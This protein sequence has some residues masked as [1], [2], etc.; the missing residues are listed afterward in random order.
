M[1]WKSEIEKKISEFVGTKITTKRFLSISGGSI[2]ESYKVSTNKGDFFVKKNSATQ[3][4]LMFNKETRGLELLCKT[5][6]IDTPEILGVVEIENDS[7]LILKYIKSGK[8]C[9]TFWDDFG[10]KIA[11]LHK[12]SNSYFGL[13]HD[14]YIGSLKQNNSE[15]DSWLDF[16]REERLERQVEL[17]RNNNAIDRETV[18]AFQR[19]YTKLE[20]IFPKESPALLHGDLWSGNFMV[21]ENGNP[22][23]IDPAAYYGHREMDLGM[24]KLFGGFDNEFYNS[25][26]NQYQLENGWEERLNYCNLYPLMVHV[27]LFGGGYLN[28]IKSIIM[29]F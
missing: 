5:N 18:N 20:E 13:D 4:P 12:N 17:A 8:R 29:K 6:V 9:N 14:N 19:F 15:H 2:N 28:S 25:Y 3:Y 10:R 1:K 21:N 23:I 24:S 26:N 16:F 11:R 7:F 22:V 27:N